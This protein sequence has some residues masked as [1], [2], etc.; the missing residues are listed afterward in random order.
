MSQRR[1]LFREEA[2]VR[3]GR[4]APIDGLLRVTAPHEW[5]FLATL[6]CALIGVLLWAVFGTVERG[7]SARCNLASSSSG[8]FGAVA[9]FPDEDARRIVVGMSAR[10]IFLG[11]E[12]AVEGEVAQVDLIDLTPTDSEDRRPAVLVSLPDTPSSARLDGD[13]C[14]LRIVTNREAPIRLIAAVPLGQE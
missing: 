8:E 2:F 10:V 4:S 9:Q 12:G 14:E 13:A 6:G 7:L 5:F 1:R 11:S 3:R